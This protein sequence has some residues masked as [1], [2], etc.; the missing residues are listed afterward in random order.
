MYWLHRTTADASLG[1]KVWAAGLVGREGRKD[2]LKTSPE[3]F[4]SSGW[5]EGLPRSIDPRAMKGKP[6]PLKGTQVPPQN[7]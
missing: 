6:R 2:A 3:Q 5:S 4:L 1:A 7:G